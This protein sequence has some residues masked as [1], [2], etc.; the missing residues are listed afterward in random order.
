MYIS[1]DCSS[2]FLHKKRL[3]FKRK[4]DVEG[5]KEE[6]DGELKGCIMYGNFPNSLT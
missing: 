5:I 2:H 3:N 4:G 6:R 1:F